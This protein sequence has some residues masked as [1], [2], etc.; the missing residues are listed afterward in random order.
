MVALD[1]G[2]AGL[3]TVALTADGEPCALPA[4]GAAGSARLRR[5]PHVAGHRG[6]GPAGRSAR[7]LPGP[8]RARPGARRARA[9]HGRRS[10]DGRG[11]RPVRPRPSGRSRL[12]PRACAVPAGSRFLIGAGFATREPSSRAPRRSMRSVPESRARRCRA[13]Q[14]GRSRCASEA[15]ARRSRERSR[16]P[17]GAALTLPSPSSRF[18]PDRAR[19]PPRPE[20]LLVRHGVAVLAYDKRGVGQSSGT[21]PGESPDGARDRRPRARCGGRRPLPGRP[22]G[23]RPR[24]GRARRPQP[25]RLDHAARGLARAAIRFLVVFSGPA[26]TA[27]ENDLYQDLAGEGERPPQ[28]TDDEID[29]QVLARGPGGV[30][31]LPWIR[32]FGSPRSGCTAAATAMSRRACPR[33]GS[34]A[35]G[36]ARPRLHRRRLP[37]RQPRA[38]RDEDRADLGDAAVGHVRARP[39]RP[40]RR[41]AQGARPR[42]GLSSAAGPPELVGVPRARRSSRQR[43][44]ALSRMYCELCGASLGPRKEV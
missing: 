4:A 38:R 29:A 21:Y 8:A 31:P 14:C 32:S 23:R 30:D 6:D 19:L 35:R 2:H 41:L 13:S 28:L 7:K 24:A 5:P 42:S 16:C 34:T 9:L 11:R 10:R 17:R 18:G 1:V 3:Q 40:G 26:V 39:V 25:G 22:A 36:R 12:R 15:R 27:D 33:A 20:A 44:S 37:E 43:R